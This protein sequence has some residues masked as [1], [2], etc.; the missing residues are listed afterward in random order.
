MLAAHHA[1]EA[2]IAA[3]MYVDGA[4]QSHSGANLIAVENPATE[5]V[6]GHIPEGTIADADAA[7]A[8][9]KA[10][11]PGWAS[12]SAIERAGFVNALAKAIDANAERLATQ[13]TAEQGKPIAQARGEIGAASN[14]LR[15]AA[16]QARRI[17]GDIVTS[18]NPSEEIHIRRH[19]YGVVV[20]LTAWNYPAALATRKLGPALVAG[21]TFCF[22][23]P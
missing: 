14:F 22:A 2:P 19:P 10:A 17:E 21:N 1:N 13:V 11:F 20:G 15:Y 6:I 23:E 4:W 8:A 16:E 7:V 3:T 18:D 9:A 12:R 5:A